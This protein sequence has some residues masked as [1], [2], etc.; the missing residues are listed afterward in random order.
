MT[1]VSARHATLNSW[2]VRE[3]HQKNHKCQGYICHPDRQSSDHELW[4]RSRTCLSGI[5]ASLDGPCISKLTEEKDI[6]TQLSASSG[7]LFDDSFREW[8]M[9]LHDIAS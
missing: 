8:V 6:L 2:C 3:G 4:T 5:R 9:S 7:V 1:Y